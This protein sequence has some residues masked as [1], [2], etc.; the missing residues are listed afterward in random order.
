MDDDKTGVTA[1]IP[2]I[3]QGEI[4]DLIDKYC[5]ILSISE[6]IGVLEIVKIEMYH[7]ANIE[8]DDG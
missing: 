6:V 7:R 2:G 4:E 8:D 1:P 5:G 3:L